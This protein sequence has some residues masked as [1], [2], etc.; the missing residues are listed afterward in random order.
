MVRFPRHRWGPRAWSSRAVAV[1]VAAVLITGCAGA[2]S[3]G[4]TDPA[5]PKP[6][7]LRMLYAT[8]EANATAVQSI[9]PRFREVFGFDLQ[10]DTQPYDALQQ[11]VYA[12]VATRS[13]HYDILVVDTPWAPALVRAL[14]P[15]GPYLE[16]PALGD[17]AP[18]R[19][20][21]MI[22]KVLADT[23][24]YDADDEVR[25]F[26]T[27]ET[28]ADLGS[29]RSQGF[30]V[31]GMPLQA[32]AMVMAY[33]KDL[34]ANPA[35]REAFRT[36]YGRPLTVPATW[37]EFA[38]VAE[39]FTRPEQ[40]LYGTTMMAGVGDW[41]TDDFKS[42]LAGFGGNGR[43][44]NDDLSLDFTGRAGEKALTWYHDLI[45]GKKSVPPGTTAA[46]WDEAASS[47]DS[48]LTAMTFNYHSLELDAAVGGEIGYAPVP[49]GV[50]RG[51][52]FGTWMLSINKYSQNKAWAYRAISWLT[53]PEQQLAMTAEGLHPSRTSVYQQL[54]G[55][56]FYTAL[57]ESL[58][59]GVGRPR[60]TNYTE[61]SR[62]IAVAVNTAAS[63]AAT[64]RAAL[65]KAAED[66]NRRLRQAGY[67]LPEG[68]P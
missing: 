10:I 24:V 54:A 52:H 43:M 47:F 48:G 26:P 38:Q 36:R 16:N 8:A 5:S 18:A 57:G 53:A 66:V 55:D 40:R 28:A 39:F 14:E 50:G 11:R 56:E 46:S 51:P 42:L 64:P 37:D 65:D 61:I 4:G 62:A 45:S 41:A 13:S 32:N 58:A 60:L 34:F 35:E 21:D 68:T 27:P 49:T 1:L 63:G 7:Q 20:D 31:Y 33:R 67:R 30:E 12:E 22:P 17:V 15:L 29:V 25:Q 3:G 2:A 23:A 44:I 6:P 19:L 59:E 9:L